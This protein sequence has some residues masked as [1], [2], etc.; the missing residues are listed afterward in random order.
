MSP[1]S[2]SGGI[3]SSQKGSLRARIRTDYYLTNPHKV[4]DRRKPAPMAAT[5]VQPVFYG[6]RS[7]TPR[8][9]LRRKDAGRLQ[10][11]RHLNSG[12]AHSLLYGDFPGGPCLGRQSSRHGPLQASHR[13]AW[14]PQEPLSCEPRSSRPPARQLQPSAWRCASMPSPLLPCL[15]VETR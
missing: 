6:A 12:I 1:L 8:R 9:R 4:A 13:A 14:Q 5:S 11:A 10:Q 15:P 2:V 3:G 7:F